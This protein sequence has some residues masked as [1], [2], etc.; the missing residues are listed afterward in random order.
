MLHM[1][2]THQSHTS[3]KAK[4]THTSDVTQAKQMDT[5]ITGVSHTNNMQ[6][7]GHWGVSE[8]G[9]PTGGCSSGMDL[10]AISAPTILCYTCI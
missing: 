10:P 5:N 4:L 3:S 6:G 8:G 1:Y 2:T 9:G 7:I